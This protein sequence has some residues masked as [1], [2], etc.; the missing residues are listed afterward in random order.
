M[1]L[2]FSKDVSN[3]Q[4][5][6]A[7]IVREVSPDEYELENLSWNGEQTKCGFLEMDFMAD[8]V[9]NGESAPTALVTFTRKSGSEP[10]DPNA[11]GSPPSATTA[12]PPGSTS[13]PALTSAPGTSPPAGSGEVVA[14]TFLSE[15]LE[16]F[17]MK[18]K[19]QIQSDV[20][21]GWR[22][23]IEFSVPVSRI[24]IWDAS[25]V[26]RSDDGLVVLVENQSYN[27]NIG[28][29]SYLEMPFNGHKVTQ[30]TSNPTAKV[31][32]IRK[33]PATGEPVTIGGNACI[34]STAAPTTEAPTTSQPS[35]SG[36]TTEVSTS[37]PTTEVSTSGPTTEVSTS[38]PT[39]EVSTSGPT[40]E[41]STSGPTTEVST[42][43]PTT[44]VST[45]EPETESP[46]TSN[47]TTHGATT[48]SRPAAGPYDYSELLRKSI[49][50]YEAE[51]SGKLPTDNRIPYRGD[52]ALGDRGDNG[53]DLTGG[54]YD[55]GDHVKFGFPMAYSTAVLA[56]GLVEYRDAY[57]ASGELDNMLDCIKWPLDY[58]IKA[59][60]AKFEFYGQVK[61]PLFLHALHTT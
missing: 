28:K 53:E 48:T 59:H 36:P 44:E 51:R 11:C 6:R 60:T 3:F 26:S 25:F 9:V 29:C 16:A 10:T 37:G 14:A 7:Q 45:S 5:W 8:K 32:F 17:N 49:L 21:G 58:F 12:A 43:G 61:W 24:E 56:W 47:P 2:K 34:T 18:L 46:T 40:T 38:G 23:R 54:W 57:Q 35:T 22:L 50:F 30:V 19:L 20:A 33:Q 13:N 55:A 52:S 1:N 41:V 31:T 15:W 4:I 27:S 39:T 42:S